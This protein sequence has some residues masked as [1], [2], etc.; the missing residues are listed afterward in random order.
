MIAKAV[1]AKL[2]NMCEQLPDNKVLDAIKFKLREE[3]A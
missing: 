3:I 2:L 1:A